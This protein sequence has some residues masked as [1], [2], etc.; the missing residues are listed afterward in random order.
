M[1]AKTLRERKAYSPK[2]G[3]IIELRNNREWS[4]IMLT[5]TR[6]KALELT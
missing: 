2:L 1:R 6:R 3:L 5:V 4:R